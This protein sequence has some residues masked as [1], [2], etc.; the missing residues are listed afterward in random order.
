LNII[1]HITSF[2]EQ[3]PDVLKKTGEQS[4]LAGFYN[5]SKTHGKYGNYLM[6]KTNGALLTSILLL[7]LSV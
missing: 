1:F 5:S 6:V 2:P 7:F 3:K 4:F